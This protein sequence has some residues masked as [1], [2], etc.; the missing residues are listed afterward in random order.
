MRAAE[1]NGP[2]TEPRWRDDEAEGVPRTSDLHG[3]RTPT[4]LSIR[5]IRAAAVSGSDRLVS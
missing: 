5:R 4:V 3:T 2:K 1:S